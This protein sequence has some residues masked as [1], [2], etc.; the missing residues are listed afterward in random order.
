MIKDN[1]LYEKIKDGLCGEEKL[2]DFF[3]DNNL[4]HHITSFDNFLGILNSGEIRYNDGSLKDSYPQS[5]NCYARYKKCISLF[6][7]VTISIEDF[8]EVVDRW[9]VFTANNKI[10]INFQYETLSNKL[11]LNKDFREEATKLRKMRIGYIE[12]LYPNKLSI[13]HAKSFLL[14]TNT[15]CQEYPNT[16]IGI[17]KLKRD[18]KFSIK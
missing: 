16:I 5:K 10:F 12:A 14:S 9:I 18:Y 13:K 1:P 2:F 7:L 15:Y 17:K 11:I 3:R 4:I 6:D 8:A